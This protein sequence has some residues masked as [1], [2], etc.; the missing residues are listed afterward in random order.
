[1]LNGR[2]KL[3]WM[4]WIKGWCEVKNYMMSL[5]SQYALILYGRHLIKTAWFCL[6]RGERYSTQ[7]VQEH[8]C[9][10]LEI[11]IVNVNGQN[12]CI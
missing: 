9:A 6:R 12:F 4:S 8:Q 10:E 2:W 3:C 11:M 5:R 7:R 1:M